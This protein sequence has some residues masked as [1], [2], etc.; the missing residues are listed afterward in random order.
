[1]KNQEGRGA[2]II[3]LIIAIAL[4]LFLSRQ[5]KNEENLPVNEDNSSEVDNIQEAE[6]E[7]EIDDDSINSEPQDLSGENEQAGSYE[8]Y[9]PE[10]VS[11]S[12]GKIV[13]FFKANWCPTC[14][15]LDVNIKSNLSNIP[16]DVII[17][18][19]DYDNSTELKQKYG[20]TY[21]HTLVQVDQE[22]NQLAKW[23]GSQTLDAIISNTI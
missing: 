4:V 8:E 9:S 23:S 6:M 19:V 5:N 22:G 16:S 10:K 2:L 13:L 1:M 15:A 17:L 12:E 18:E 11:N 3:I 21:Q 20:V 14:R 7:S